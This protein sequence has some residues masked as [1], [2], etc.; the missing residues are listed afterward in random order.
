MMIV[1]NGQIAEFCAEPGE[2]TYDA[3]SEPT[4]FSGDLSDSIMETFQQIGKRFT[5]G[6]EPP[7]DQRVYY[8]YMHYS[9]RRFSGHSCGFCYG[10]NMYSSLMD[11]AIK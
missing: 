7:K 9:R 3:S 8:F 10:K 6:G 5:F 11:V 1:D 4:I 2:Y